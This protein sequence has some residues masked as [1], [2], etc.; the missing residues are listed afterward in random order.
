MQIIMV[1]AVFALGLFG[2]NKLM[3]YKKDNIVFDFED[4][5]TNQE[6]YV[7]AILSELEKEGR[8]ATYQGDATFMVDGRR[9]TLVE[10][11]ISMGPGI[12]QR[13]ILQAGK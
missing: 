8:E 12:L 2:F 7:K 13:T 1:L 11:N 5:Y 9:Y 10:R 3:G 4:R 6:A